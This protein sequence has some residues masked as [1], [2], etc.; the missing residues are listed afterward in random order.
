MFLGQGVLWQ[1]VAN[2]LESS[3]GARNGKGQTTRNSNGQGGSNGQVR[4]T[5]ASDA[6]PKANVLIRRI[7]FLPP[8]RD[9]VELEERRRVF[10]NVFLMDRF[11]SI[12]TGWNLSLTTTDEE[13]RIEVPTPYFG[14]SEPPRHDAYDAP[15]PAD[16]DQTSLGAFA[17][18]IEAT[19]SLSLRWLLRFKQL[20]LRLVCW[21]LFLPERWR[22]A[23][24]RNADNNLAPNL[25]A[26]H[27]THNTAV[28]LLHQ[29][30]AY[31]SS[32]WL[33]VLP[34]AIRLPS[35]SSA[36]TCLAAA[37][38]LA[39]IA[40]H[41]L[42][43][44]DL[45][46]NPQIAFCLFVCGRMVL[47]HSTYH[48]LPLPAAFDRMTDSLWEISRRWRGTD[49]TDVTDNTL[50]DYE[51]L[52]SKF[53][54]RL[55]HAKQMGASLYVRQ[56]AYSEDA[57]PTA[58]TTTFVPSTG[59]MVYSTVPQNHQ[60]LSFG[61]SQ[62]ISRTGLGESADSMSLAFPPLP[63]AFQGAV[64]MDSGVT[65]GFDSIHGSVY[66]NGTGM[67]DYSASL[68]GGLG[69]DKDMLDDL[70]SF[71]DYSFLP[72]QRVSTYTLPDV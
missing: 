26:A 63:L 52:A 69:G 11:C 20:D 48:R 18:C 29:G 4:S 59:D 32:E 13:G 12:A 27:M 34:P 7:A 33:S 25:V 42:R 53:S 3:A 17:S 50:G 15:S 28:V 71:L 44:T 66:G 47:A 45:L 46:T 65:L 21:K 57:E 55:V 22:D 60:P 64:T 37:A 23:N 30:I 62:G 1:Q 14:V 41:V 16:G 54:S 2:C 5:T 36:G 35:P 61:S 68:G 43:E 58:V 40:A 9:W 19:E 67:P 24:S 31:P 51:N 38:E 56:A 6:R 10:W 39:A 8:A 70:N 49:S 72:D